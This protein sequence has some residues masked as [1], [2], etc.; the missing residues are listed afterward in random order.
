MN[1]SEIR[2][3]R[4]QIISVLENHL[5]EIDFF[6]CGGSNP[7]G[8]ANTVCPDGGCESGHWAEHVADKIV[9]IL[10]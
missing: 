2:T 5:L 6:E 1:A 8:P 7:W 9:E 4:E 10:Q 3:L